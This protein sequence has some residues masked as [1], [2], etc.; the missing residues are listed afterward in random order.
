MQN[1]RNTE[2]KERILSIFDSVHTATASDVHGQLSDID[3]STIY[4]NIKRFV[5]DGVLKEVQ[6]GKGERTYEKVTEDHEHFI[7]RRCRVVQELSIGKEILAVVIPRGVDIN[8]CD[9]TISGVC[10]SCA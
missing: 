10:T 1:R 9:L 6:I 8:I 5:E 4:R 7:C 3:P 2:N